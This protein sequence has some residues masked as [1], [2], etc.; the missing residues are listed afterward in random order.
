MILTVVIPVLALIFAAT[1][2]AVTLQPS[3]SQDR[4]PDSPQA[5]RA[6][7]LSP[8]A[9][10]QVADRVLAH[11]D[12]PQRQRGHKL[13]AIRVTV[14]D[15]ADA[16]GAATTVV[17]VVLFDHTALESRRVTLDPAT[18]RLLRNDLLPGRPQRSERELAEASS[19]VQRDP[20]LARLLEDGAVLDGGFIIDDPRG[21]RRRMIQ[22][23][24]ISADRR[25][26]LR[27]IVVDLTR[28]QIASVSLANGG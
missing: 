12:L 28:G 18:N 27:T 23:K 24:L 20:T 26:P 15:M 13:A 7:S 3:A 8:E 10:A 25:S 17:T 11:P 5:R 22:M 4:K 1:T 14:D 16:G 9:S 2:T 6:V 19:I 21:S